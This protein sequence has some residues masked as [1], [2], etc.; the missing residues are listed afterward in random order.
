MKSFSVIGAGKVGASL[1][2]A[3]SGSWRLE[4]I[5]NRTSASKAIKFIGA[6]E[7]AE[8]IS[9]CLSSDIIIFAVPDD[10]IQKV[11]SSVK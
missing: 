4:K 10:A 3:L 8:T 5:Y 2:R 6:G 9:E 7:I 11:Y 1:A